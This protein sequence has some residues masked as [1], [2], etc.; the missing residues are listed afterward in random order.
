MFFSTFEVFTFYFAVMYLP[1]ADVMTYW[2]AAPIYVAAASPLLLGE[3]VGWRRWTAIAIRLYRR[4]DRAQSVRSD[5]LRTSD[6]LHS[7][8]AGLRLHVDFR[9]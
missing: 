7:R 5:V 3:K 6:H 4:S 9:A 2:L 8:H 1:L